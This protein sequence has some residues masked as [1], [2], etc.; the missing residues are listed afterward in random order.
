MDHFRIVN[1]PLDMFEEDLTAFCIKH[2]LKLEEDA[3]D[4]STFKFSRKKPF[5]SSRYALS[6]INGNFIVEQLGN[7]VIC[8]IKLSYRDAFITFLEFLIF[9]ALAT[10]LFILR[11]PITIANE[12]LTLEIFSGLMLLITA[13]IV[14]R[15]YFDH[16]DFLN[17]FKKDFKQNFEG[18]VPKK[19]KHIPIN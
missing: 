7:E 16:R 13:G 15:D 1:R 8:S 2:N 18:Y 9:L 10:I 5:F 4:N 3:E 17:L 6:S 19:Q 12:I 11:G 14:F